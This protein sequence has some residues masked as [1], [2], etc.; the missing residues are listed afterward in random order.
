M[1]EKEKEIISRLSKTVAKLNE[2]DQKYILGIGE[3]MVL[4]RESNLDEAEDAA[5]AN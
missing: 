2:S 1:S 3:G 4:A 5:V